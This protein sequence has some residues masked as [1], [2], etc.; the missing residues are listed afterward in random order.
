MI[1]MYVYIKIVS[2]TI[3]KKCSIDD[4]C[5]LELM[6]NI[7]S[8]TCT[9]PQPYFWHEDIHACYGCAPGW[10]K[11]QTNKC[12]LFAISNS[13]GVTWYKAKKTCKSLIA[14][15]LMIN[16]IHEFIALQNLIEY[17]LNGNDE[18]IASLYFYQ[19]WSELYTW[20]NNDEKEDFFD[21]IQIRQNSITN[22]ICLQYVSCIQQSQYICEASP[23]IQSKLETNKAEIERS[24]INLRAKV[25]AVTT[26]RT[27]L[28]TTI[29][30]TAKTTTT[31][32]KTGSNVNNVV[33]A[34]TGG[35]NAAG[36]ISNALGNSLIIENT[37]NI[38]DQQSVL[39]LS[40]SGDDNSNK[41]LNNIL[42]Y[43][44]ITIGIITLIIITIIVIYCISK[45][46]N[47]S[48]SRTSFTSVVSQE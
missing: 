4:D 12:L 3:E 16:N 33:D 36:Q 45:N 34:L 22:T 44:G 2:I 27:T 43:G 30:T 41:G 38:N 15:P 23:L 6:C 17:L 11:L 31:T 7:E 5:D 32:K 39:G 35:I 19:E 46:K 9:C 28:R 8:H 26:K 42:L 48:N 20:C 29:K 25:P 1:L 21:C 37:N 24:E 13:S 14:Q 47:S 40:S 10:L 18:L